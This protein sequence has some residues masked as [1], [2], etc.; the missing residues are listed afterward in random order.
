MWRCWG[1]EEE[2]GSSPSRTAAP[3]GGSPSLEGPC[4]APCA[5]ARGPA[6]ACHW[7][8]IKLWA[9]GRWQLEGAPCRWLSPPPTEDDSSLRAEQGSLA[10][11]PQA[12]PQPPCVSGPPHESSSPQYPGPGANS[13]SSPSPP[14]HRYHLPKHPRTWLHPPT[15][16]PMVSPSSGP[17][18][19]VPKPGDSGYETKT[20]FSA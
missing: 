4:C 11:L 1:S 16:P 19:R 20:P 8:L 18:S 15:P 12:P 17:S 14:P 7:N 5:A 13:R 6:P 2:E 10:K 9:V 3:L